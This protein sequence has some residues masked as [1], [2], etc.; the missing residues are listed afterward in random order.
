MTP[1]SSG[2]GD[3]HIFLDIVY[4]AHLGYNCTKFGDPN[5]IL[6]DIHVIVLK[7]LK[8]N[9]FLIFFKLNFFLDK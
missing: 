3:F 9:T 8:K 7:K 1:L 5:S 2:V 4:H 6:L